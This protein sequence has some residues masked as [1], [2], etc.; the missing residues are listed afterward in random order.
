M[1]EIEYIAVKDIILDDRNPRVAPALEPL[2][3]PPGQEFLEIAIGQH[4]PDEDDK[5]QSS[6]YSSLKASI[7][8]YKG[9]IQPIVVTPDSSGQ[10]VVI[11]GNTRV[12]IFRELALENAD[13]DWSRIPAM[14]RKGLQEQGEHAIRLQ[15]HLVGPRPWRPYAKAKY[16]HDL[17]TNKQM[18]MNEILDFCG[19]SAKKRDIEEYIHA[20][21]DM[22][23]YYLPLVGQNAP[24]LSRFSAF[25]ELQKPGIKS[26]IVKAGFTL[27]DFGKWIN[28]SNISPLNSVRHLPRILAN[29][30]ARKRFLTH[31]ARDAMRLL[32]QPSST[33]V[34]KEASLDQLANALATKIRSLN[35]EDIRSLAETQDS[36]RTQA[37]LDCWDEVNALCRHLGH[38]PSE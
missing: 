5:G 12:C 31:D 4:S 10:Y 37:I 17:Y 3:G 32:E 35:F 23:T 26:A 9:L 15:A 20:Y 19:G 14:V 2:V 1:L 8:A 25:V 21:I 16:L 33:T 38:S 22:Q 6:T 29:P 24:D 36:P 18:S 34:I 11:E 7:R 13:G 28:G 27:G 30:E